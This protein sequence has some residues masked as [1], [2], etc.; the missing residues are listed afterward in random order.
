MLA[1]VAPQ[2]DPALIQDSNYV[3]VDAGTGVIGE[4]AVM[5]IPIVALALLN[6]PADDVQKALREVDWLSVL[7][8]PP[9][10]SVE[11]RACALRLRWCVLCWR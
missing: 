8:R 9:Q 6:F 11:P 7:Y 5:S 10:D 1:V 4:P 2:V 3:M